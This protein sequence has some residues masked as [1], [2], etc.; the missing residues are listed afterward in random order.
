VV[1][2]SDVPKEIPQA[3]WKLLKTKSDESPYG[4]DE[5]DP[6]PWRVGWYER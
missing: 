5:D 1:D 2:I 6:Y 3:V 4:G